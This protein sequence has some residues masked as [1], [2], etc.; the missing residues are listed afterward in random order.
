MEPDPSISSK[1]AKLEDTLVR[2]HTWNDLYIEVA[3]ATSGLR[4]LGVGVGDRVVA[5]TPNNSEAV[6]LVLATSSLGAIWSSVAPEFGVTAVLERF[7]QVGDH[8]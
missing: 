3:Q 1:T 5:L 2:T 4:K 6:I 8:T 7:T